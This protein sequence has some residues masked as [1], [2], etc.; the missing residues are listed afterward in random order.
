MS[1]KVVSLIIVAVLSLLAVYFV[2]IG[3]FEYAVLCITLMFTLSNL[4]RYRSFKQ[5]GQLKEAK[6]MLTM[7]VILGISFLAAL[8]V[9]VV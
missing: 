6:W 4:F 9:V 3:N 2:V 5:Q 1:E 7:A 8:Y